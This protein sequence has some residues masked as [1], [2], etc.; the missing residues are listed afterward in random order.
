ML[1]PINPV[2]LI[3]TWHAT[4][5]MRTLQVDRSEVEEVV[6]NWQHTWPGR[7]GPNGT[8]RHYVGF[9]IIVLL[10]GDGRTVITVKLRTEVPYIHGVHSNHDR[11]APLTA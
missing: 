2:D 7:T 6:R 4:E 3:Y 5:R 10:G 8:S 9:E 1:S 11:P